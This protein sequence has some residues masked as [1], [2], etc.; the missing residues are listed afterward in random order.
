[1]ILALWCCCWAAL[2]WPCGYRG[3]TASL[4]VSALL[5]VPCRNGLDNSSRLQLLPKNIAVSGNVVD[6][7]RPGSPHR[8]HWRWRDYARNCAQTSGHKV[9]ESRGRSRVGSSAGRYCRSVH[10]FSHTSAG[11]CGSSAPN[12]PVRLLSRPYKKC[13]YRTLLFN[14]SCWEAL[15]EIYNGTAWMIL[16]TAWI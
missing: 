8:C 16:W 2:G 12:C 10:L 13:Q 9:E 5:S 1:M 11:F 3:L 7:L 14:N 6:K 4:S 15:L